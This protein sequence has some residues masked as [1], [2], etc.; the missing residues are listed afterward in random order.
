[1][2]REFELSQAAAPRHHQLHTDDGEAGAKGEG[3][4]LEALK[5]R[6][7]GAHHIIAP[8]QGK[9]SDMCGAERGDRG[10]RY[11]RKT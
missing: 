9:V 8:A 3:E 6:Q 5:A 4:G 1:M 7:R 11:G 10:V 2:R